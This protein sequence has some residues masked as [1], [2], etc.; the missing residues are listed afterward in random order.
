MKI[1]RL[2]MKVDHHYENG[3][4]PLEQ[5]VPRSAIEIF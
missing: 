3:N 4:G 1:F 5:T 2:N